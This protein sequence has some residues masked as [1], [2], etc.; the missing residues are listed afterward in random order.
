MMRGLFMKKKWR[1]RETMELCK[2]M[3][4][5]LRAGIP[6]IECMAIVEDQ[7]RGGKKEQIRT[8][9]TNIIAGVPIENAFKGDHFPSLFISMIGIAQ[10]H[11]K[12]ADTFNTLG[13][14]FDRKSSFREQIIQKITYPLFLLL[15][16][17]SLLLYF[18]L[19]LLPQFQELLGDFDSELPLGTTLLFSLQSFVQHNYIFILL[20]FLLIL[21]LFSSLY[22]GLSKKNRLVHVL[23]RLPVI[24]N[25]IKIYFTN[26]FTS[27]LGLLLESG[28]GI[29]EAL[30]DIRKQTPYKQL[31]PYIVEIEKHILVGK[32]LSSVN[33]SLPILHREYYR[34]TAL[35]EQLG[36]LGAQLILCSHLM[37]E[38]IEAQIL[39]VLKWLEPML[40][41]FLG[42][43]IAFVVLSIFLP[44]TQLIQS[45]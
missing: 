12:L 18:L 44:I 34:L 1:D 6:L 14:W 21:L 36:T 31:Q 35:G 27:Q 4:S 41:L 33:L 17:L 29:W 22:Y 16:V 9:R 11:G 28:M 25:M 2:K 19:Y 42:S 40:L 15:F 38:K 24:S 10:T 32:P 8:I 23:I 20:L 7:Y 39:F 26:Y 5:L 30:I 3:S 13:E 45:I 37:E 43:I